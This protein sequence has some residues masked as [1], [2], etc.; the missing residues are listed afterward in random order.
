MNISSLFEEKIVTIMSTS[1]HHNPF[2]PTHPAW[3]TTNNMPQ[4]EMTK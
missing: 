4:E 2:W 1:S 3:T